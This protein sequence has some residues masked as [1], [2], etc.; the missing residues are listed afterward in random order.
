LKLQ[1]LNQQVGALLPLTRPPIKPGRTL[2]TH[3]MGYF[4]A[5]VEFPDATAARVAEGISLCF[6]GGGTRVTATVK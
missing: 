1:I 3:Y 2:V 4:P 5:H 6:C